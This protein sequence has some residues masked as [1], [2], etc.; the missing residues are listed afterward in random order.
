MALPQPLGDS[1]RLNAKGELTEIPRGPER[2]H[3]PE[4]PL[5]QGFLATTVLWFPDNTNQMMGMNR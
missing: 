3:E 5:G 2:P 1:I 4:I